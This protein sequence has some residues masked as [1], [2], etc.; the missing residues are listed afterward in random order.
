LK[1]AGLGKPIKTILITSPEPYEGKSTVSANLAIAFAQAGQK[2]LI[3]DADLRRPRVHELFGLD[4]DIGLTTLLVG[5]ASM[6]EVIRETGIDNLYAITCGPIPPNP[7]ELLESERMREVLEELKQKFDIIILD[8]P[9]VMGMAD[10]VILSSICDGTLIVARYN[11]TSRSAFNQARKLLE[12]VKAN[13]LGAILNEMDVRRAKYGGY[14]YYY[15]YYY[16]EEGGER[17]KKRTRH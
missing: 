4:R 9:L 10:A 8:S 11:S 7:A 12:N 13:I 3:L 14:Y 1:F 17:R 2:T 15:Y 6:E 16:Y 5:E